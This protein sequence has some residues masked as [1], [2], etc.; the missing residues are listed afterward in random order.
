MVRIAVPLWVSVTAAIGAC[1]AGCGDSADLGP[2]PKPAFTVDAGNTLDVGALDAATAET[3]SPDT[4]ADPGMA[5]ALTWEDAATT[6]DSPV[7]DTAETL[8]VADT[9]PD[10]DPADAAADQAVSADAAPT[11]N[12]CLFTQQP[13][14][15]H[16][17]GKGPYALAPADE[18]EYAP[19]GL[20]GNYH[21][22]LVV[23][24]DAPG[25]WPTVFFLPGK[26]LYEGGG[27]SAKLGQP[28]RALLDHI[29]SHGYVVAFVRV[30]SGLL[31]ADHLRMADDLLL[32]AKALTDKV[33]VASPSKVAYVGHSMGAKVALLAAWKTLNSDQSNAHADPAAVLLFSI[34]NEPPPIGTYQNALD[35]AKVMFKDAP[36][37]FT[38][39]TGADDGT[40]TWN[41]PKKPNA[42]A[43]FDALPTTRKQ[44]FVV[45]GTGKDDPNPPTKPELVDDHSAP[46]TIEGK[47]GGIA[48]MALTDSHLDALD[49]YGF[50]KWTVGSLNAHFKAGDPAWAYGAQRTHGG[51]LPDGKAIAHEVAGQ[52]WTV[53]PGL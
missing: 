1:L 27:F 35:K 9:A 33:S 17:G 53:F 32:A 48:D 46:M 7:Q 25:V 44:L 52:G 47:P 37:W 6:A 40:A 12:G 43:L 11:C 2:A 38:F 24:P 10:S 5:E 50:W 41:D 51:N 4:A 21:K 31:D 15:P 23:R 20:T 45:H 13:P 26:S 34:A 36:T 29:A 30:E 42:K 16:P 22:M 19:G 39:A 8:T 3:S 14:S 28:Y 18:F 49:W